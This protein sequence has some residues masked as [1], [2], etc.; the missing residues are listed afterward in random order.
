MTA[1]K[2]TN[3]APTSG[4][5]RL[6]VREL[7]MARRA[8]RLRVTELGYYSSES[9]PTR[10]A[11]RAGH[12]GK[13]G[14]CLESSKGRYPKWRAPKLV[15][16]S[17]ETRTSTG[18]RRARKLARGVRRRAGGKGLLTQ[19]LA[20]GLSYFIVTAASKEVLEHEVKP[21]I[22]TFMKERGLELSS[23]KTCIT[24]IEDGFD[25]LGQNVR[26]YK[27]GKRHTLEGRN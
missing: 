18:E 20:C 15:E 21:L 5:I 17:P 27:T 12:R 22:E 23:E 3:A 8:E 7:G 14:R 24:H 13:P 2:G 9:R 19:Y 10:E 4:S 1:L 11:R 6:G 16:Y 26:K 25:F